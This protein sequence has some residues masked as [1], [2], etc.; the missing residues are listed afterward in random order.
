MKIRLYFTPLPAVLSLGLL[1]AL[2][3]WLAACVLNGITAALPLPFAVFYSALFVLCAWALW[4]TYAL[5]RWASW[6]SPERLLIFA[7]HVDD[8]AIAAGA[9]GAR[10]HRLGGATR[11]VYIAPDTVAEIAAR[12]AA[13]AAAAWREAG[14]GKNDLVHLTLLPPLGQRDPASLRA[15]APAL[16]SI[17][18]EFQPTVV[19]VPMFEGGHIHHD[20]TAILM[21]SITTA[22]DGFRLFEAPEYSPLVSLSHTPH[23]II[24]LCARWLFGLVSYYGPPDGVDGRPIVRFRLDPIDLDCKR[25]MLSAFVSQNAASLV[26]TRSYPDR[27]VFCLPG[28]SRRV[29]LKSMRSYSRFVSILRRNVPS[30]IVDRVFPLQF[31]Y[32][33]REDAWTDWWRDW[34]P[35]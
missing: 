8:C 28:A 24:A 9:I 17:V 33:L 3:W 13:E 15:V 31:G 29:S 35:V 14:V 25:R 19:I 16:R 10:N 18:E 22:Q 23:R 26:A 30:A 21:R 1:A 12:R 32:V 5:E 20:M 7:P 34:P 4:R 6:D 27:L 2:L 11:V